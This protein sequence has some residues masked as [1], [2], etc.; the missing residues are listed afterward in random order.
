MSTRRQFTSSALR[1]LALLGLILTLAVTALTTTPAHAAKAQT[2]AAT[3]P[4]LTGVLNLRAEDA[5]TNEG[6][7]SATVYVWNQ[8]GTLV[9]KGITDVKGYFE[10]K[11]AQ[12]IYT[13]EVNGAGYETYG[14]AFKIASRET[15]DVQAQMKSVA[16]LGTFSLYAGDP[17]KGTPVAGAS[18]LIW[19][20]AG[21]IIVEGETNKL[22]EYKAGLAA[23]SYG[24]LITAEGYKNFEQSFEIAAQGNTDIKAK[25]EAVANPEGVLTMQVVDASGKGPIYEARVFI[26]NT[27][28]QLVTK[29][30]TGKLGDFTVGLPDGTYIVEVASAGYSTHSDKIVITSKVE[31][32][33][34]VMMT[35]EGR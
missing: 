31:T 10:T 21:G 25:L 7:A 29:G 17:I 5:S 8:K 2:D 3:S 27:D 33:L 19:S 13:L 24:L 15:T 35:W 32:F 20:L 22:G 26:Y 12:G 1:A 23:G 9:L 28:G 16:L 18:V 6:I 14:Q 4:R 34:E 11:L 30:L